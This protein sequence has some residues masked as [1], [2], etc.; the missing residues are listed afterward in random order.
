MA[1]NYWDEGWSPVDVEAYLARQDELPPEDDRPDAREL[2]EFDDPE[3]VARRRARAH[4][5]DP[6]REEHDG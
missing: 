1:R 2:A 5:R 3:W 4:R 6:E